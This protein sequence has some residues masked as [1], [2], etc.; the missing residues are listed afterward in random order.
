MAITNKALLKRLRT[1]MELYW[2]LI[3]NTGDEEK[4]L[5]DQFC[6]FLSDFSEVEKRFATLMK[7][8]E[9]LSKNHDKE[10]D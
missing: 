2:E 7:K 5:R 10:E 1:N 3:K 8:V 9:K 4:I 6:N